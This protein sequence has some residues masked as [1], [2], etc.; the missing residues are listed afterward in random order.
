[1]FI[2]A[3]G[4]EGVHLVAQLHVAASIACAT[5]LSARRLRR[6]K[7][8]R[9]TLGLSLDGLTRLLVS[10]ETLAKTLKVVI[11]CGGL[12]RGPLDGVADRAGEA[13]HA[14]DCLTRCQGSMFSVK[15]RADSR[16]P[17]W[18]KATGP[19]KCPDEKKNVEVAGIDPAA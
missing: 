13:L 18:D 11:L 7:W 15:S 6:K 12:A 17:D 16:S 3:Q 4:E 19:E 9:L 5:Q 14:A 8:K 1:V 2:A 10:H